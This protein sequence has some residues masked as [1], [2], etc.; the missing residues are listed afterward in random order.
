[1]NL[2][3]LTATAGEQ[4]QLRES[5][6]G[7]QRTVSTH[8]NTHHGKIFGHEATLVEG[9]IGAVNTAQALT[10]ALNSRSFDGVLQTGIGGA[11][12]SS[13]LTTGD[14]A[15]ANEEI[16]GDLGIA[17]P[18]RYALADEIGIPVIDGDPPRFNRMP[19]DARLS[20]R[21]ETVARARSET[22]EYTTR[23]G[24]FVTVQQ[25]TGCSS[26]ASEL[27]ERFEGICENME[28]AAAAHICA[29]YD[30]PF[31]EVRGISNIVEDRD[32]SKWDIPLA[33]NRAQDVL[34]GLLEKLG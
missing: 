32:F 34:L 18:D 5:L 6:G 31:A 20:D 23:R 16:Y 4:D 21:A 19:V 28:G 30:V 12:P 22:S 10:A 15:V 2:L 24:P 29:L 27:E 8:R 33:T 26:L 11:Y 9:G 14:V 7:L 25:C 3:L 1:V 13:G 17:L